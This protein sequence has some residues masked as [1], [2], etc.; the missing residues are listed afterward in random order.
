MKEEITSYFLIF[1]SDH[2]LLTVKL[3]HSKTFLELV[4]IFSCYV[5]RNSAYI[6]SMFSYETVHSVELDW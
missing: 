4:S 2:K 5:F 6:L 1:F 3:K